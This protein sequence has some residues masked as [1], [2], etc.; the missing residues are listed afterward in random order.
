MKTYVSVTG[1]TLKPELE[2]YAAG[3]LARI[4]RRIPRKYRAQADF[5]IELK[6][7]VA[8][9]TKHNTCGIVL[10]FDGVELRAQETTQH[11]YAALDI[12]A[13]QI[14]SQLKSHLQE[15]RLGLLHRLKRAG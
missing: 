13:V 6:R 1:L 11:M 9:D 8:K 12:C 2:K 5:Q 3:K 7:A 4:S 14:E 10:S 15:N